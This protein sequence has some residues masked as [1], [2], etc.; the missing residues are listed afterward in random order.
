MSHI[1]KIKDLGRDAFENLY[2]VIIPPVPGVVGF[3]E[4]RFRITSFDVP[5]VPKPSVYE[6]PYKTA[7]VQKVGS[8]FEYDYEFELP[9]RMDRNWL[10]DAFFQAWMKLGLNHVTGLIDETLIPKVPVIVMMTDSNDFP[11]GKL[12]TFEDAFPLQR[13][14]VGL[15]QDGDSPLERSYTFQFSVMEEV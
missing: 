1:K 2:D 13:G 6:I 5:A 4:V 9:I 12:W 15:S 11:T 14:D 7:S 8:K 10:V 3:D